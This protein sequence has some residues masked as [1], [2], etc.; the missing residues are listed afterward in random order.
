MPENVIK[1]NHCK[2]SQQRLRLLCSHVGK[3]DF[4]FKC[5]KKIIRQPV[6]IGKTTL[7]FTTT[8]IKIF[9]DYKYLGF[10]TQLVI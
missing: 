4:T 1:E 5:L 3:M 10:R 6:C 2:F 8:T 7:F 9:T